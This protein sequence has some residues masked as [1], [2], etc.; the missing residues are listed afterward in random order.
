LKFTFARFNFF[1]DFREN[2]AP[3]FLAKK[4]FAIGV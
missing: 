4:N 1:A 3:R 2:S